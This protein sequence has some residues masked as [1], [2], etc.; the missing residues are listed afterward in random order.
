MSWE[1]AVQERSSWSRSNTLKL[2][3]SLL[4]IT[5]Y[6]AVGLLCCQ[7]ICCSKYSQWKNDKGGLS[8]NSSGKPQIIS[9]RLALGCS[10]VFQQDN[11]LKHTSAVIKECWNHA[12]TEVL[13]STSQSSDLTPPHQHVD[14]AE[15]TSLCQEANKFNWT[16][17]ILSREVKNSARGLTETCGWLSEAPNWGEKGRGTCN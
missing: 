8:P 14:C 5:W 16:S 1:A 15:E 12:R 7:W 10:L 17:T 3:W 9:R 13:E 4:L 2:D 6:Y 11:N